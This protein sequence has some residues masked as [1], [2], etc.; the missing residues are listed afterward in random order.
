[1]QFF[2][3]YKVVDGCGTL[4]STHLVNLHQNEYMQAPKSFLDS[5][6]SLKMQQ[7]STILTIDQKW[8]ITLLPFSYQIQ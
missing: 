5:N 7:K 1:M 2:I 8:I 6:F 4:P 3:L